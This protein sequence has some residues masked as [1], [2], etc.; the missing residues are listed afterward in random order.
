MIYYH[1][2]GILSKELLLDLNSTS[3]YF[4]FSGSVPGSF[5]FDSVFDCNHSVPWTLIK[6]KVPIFKMPASSFSIV[7]FEVELASVY[8]GKVNCVYR[9]PEG[10]KSCSLS[11][12]SHDLKIHLCQAAII[13]SR[14]IRNV[15][16]NKLVWEN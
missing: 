12:E 10:S 5:N 3:S 6:G 15:L 1:A 16:F 9:L 13:F 14:K 4:S 11:P 8:G 7:N 2:A